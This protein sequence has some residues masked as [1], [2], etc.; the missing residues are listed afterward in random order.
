MPCEQCAHWLRGE[1]PPAEWPAGTA[2]GSSGSYYPRGPTPQETPPDCS[3][4]QPPVACP[5]SLRGLEGILDLLSDLHVRF[6]DVLCFFG[7]DV[8]ISGGGP[9]PSSEGAQTRP[10]WSPLPSQAGIPACQVHTPGAG[11]HGALP[12][13]GSR[14]PHLRRAGS[15]RPRPPQRQIPRERGPQG[16]GREPTADNMSFSE[17]TGSLRSP[18]G[19]RHHRSGLRRRR[20]PGRVRTRGS[21]TLQ[22]PRSAPPGAPEALVAMGAPGPASSTERAEGR[23]PLAFAS[24]RTPGRGVS[25]RGVEEGG[26]SQG[27]KLARERA[28]PGGKCRTGRGRRKRR[29]L[30]EP[31]RLCGFDDLQSLFAEPVVTSPCGSGQ[32]KG[33]L[34]VYS[35]QRDFSCQVGLWSCSRADPHGR[36]SSAPRVRLGAVVQ[37]A[38]AI[39]SR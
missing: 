25:C 10:A 20:G 24:I 5:Q 9:L 13:R 37:C 28:Q 14:A 36:Q 34:Q 12:D 29:V 23:W 38:P 21:A 35:H 17:V 15:R 19:Q 33:R 1:P 22:S 4:H 16:P 27:E 18:A 26:R 11:R 30:D 39:W 8:P 31:R 32:A 2:P 3:A 6:L 7:V